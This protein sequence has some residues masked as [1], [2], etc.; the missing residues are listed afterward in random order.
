MLEDD[1]NYINSGH[2]EH[3]FETR[4]KLNMELRVLG[5][6]GGVG[7]GLRTTTLLLNEHILFDAGTGVG[8]LSLEEMA[9]IRHIFLTHSHLDHI[10]DIPLLVD[11]VFEQI[12]QPIVVH[13]LYETIEALRRHIFNN[14]IWPDF[15]K[16]PSPDNPVLKF[17]EMK[18]GE[19][20]DVNGC[21][22][23]MIPVNHLVP[24]AGYRVSCDDKSFAFSGDTSSNDTFWEALNKHDN[25]DMLI[26]ES[27]FLNKDIELSIQAGHYCARL[28]A[29]DLKKL[30]HTPEVYITHNKPGE[31]DEIMAECKAAISDRTIHRL[32]GGDC[33]KL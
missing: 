28:L 33:F 25:L 9:G 14:V 3:S 2:G 6:S 19:V 11:S 31:E 17:E 26:V 20:V 13:G 4:S 7:A 8:D 5:C 10:A 18:P 1:M 23:E 24:G 30:E 15:S 21:K 29:D 22:M 16:L 32:V 27:A 12:K